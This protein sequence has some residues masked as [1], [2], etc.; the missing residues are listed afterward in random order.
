GG[1]DLATSR[2]SGRPAPRHPGGIANVADWV[3]AEAYSREEHAVGWWPIDPNFGPAFYAYTYPEPPRLRDAA[4]EQAGAFFDA[5]L[6]EFILTDD[7][8]RAEPDPDAAV[9][10]FLE[11]TYAVG[12]SLGGWDRVALEP[13]EHRRAIRRALGAR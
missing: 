3:M 13:A 12:A 11:S 10:A 7:A 9:L 6:G 2:Y 5:E 1:F 8:L 4:I